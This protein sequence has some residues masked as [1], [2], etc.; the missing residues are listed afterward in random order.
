MRS[1][2]HKTP[3]ALELV[4]IL[5]HASAVC[6]AIEMLTF[7]AYL[8]LSA[9]ISAFAMRCSVQEHARVLASVLRVPF[10]AFAGAFALIPTAFVPS[11]LPLLVFVVQ[12]ADALCDGF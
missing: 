11:L 2:L 8:S 12:G 5:D 10:C 4:G 6:Y 7:V 1:I 3:G 9:R